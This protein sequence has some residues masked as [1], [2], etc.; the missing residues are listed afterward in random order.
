MT[1]R[2]RRDQRGQ[3]TLIEIASALIL[4]AVI[5]TMV[6]SSLDTAGKAVAGTSLRVT[7][8][9][10]A[11]TLMAVLTKDL[12][13][14]TR[15]QAGGSPFASAAATDVTFYANLDNTTGGPRKIRMYVNASGIII[16][17][18]QT[19]DA[20]SVAP[21]YTYTGASKLRYVGRYLANTS[22]DPV[23]RYYD[24]SGTE[25]AAPL[26]DADKLAVDSIRITLVVRSSTHLPV[27]NVTL[28]D[29]V[30]LPNVDYQTT[31]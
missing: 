10:E 18:V 27:G 4:L 17:S 30:R 8:L 7:N 19:P 26:S 12:R 15:L 16:A 13:T 29:Q 2:R 14:A 3:T 23:F 21:N 20:S 25:L 1:S 5:M 22:A 11:R 9:D 28:V 31:G 24:D 6:Y